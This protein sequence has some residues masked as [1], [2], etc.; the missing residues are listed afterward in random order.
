MRGGMRRRWWILGMLMILLGCSEDESDRAVV[1][2]GIDVHCA[3]ESRSRPGLGD[4]DVKV[5]C[6]H[7]AE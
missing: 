7:P 3:G 4:T 2:P 1:G 6:Q 5:T